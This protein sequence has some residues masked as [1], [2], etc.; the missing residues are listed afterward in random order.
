MVVAWMCCYCCLCTCICA[1]SPNVTSL[2]FDVRSTTLTC[3]STGGPATTVTWRRNGAV[4]TLNSTHQQTKRLVD[5][6]TSTYQT[7]LN[8]VGQS[9]I[10]GTYNCTVE[11]VRGESSEMVVLT[12]E[13]LATWHIHTFLL[14]IVHTTVAQIPP[15][16]GNLYFLQVN[17][18]WKGKCQG[19]LLAGTE[20]KTAQIG[21]ILGYF[22]RALF[23]EV[24]LLSTRKQSK[25]S[26]RRPICVHPWHFCHNHA[27]KE[28][29]HMQM[30][31]IK[32]RPN[33][34]RNADL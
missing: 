30:C 19:F 13:A 23:N 26:F 25:K 31:R 7:V 14:F 21:F 32:E 1:G 2:T 10:V 9:G 18:A 15:C 3:T 29:L 27:M 28:L 34:T 16:Y 5:P 24:F 4:I 8:I 17:R 22:Y 11:N 20:K 6:V 33:V 12:S